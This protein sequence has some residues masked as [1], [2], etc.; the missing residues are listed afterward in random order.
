MYL[1]AAHA[2]RTKHER[3]MI[4]WAL[5]IAGKN[6]KGNSP[7][8]LLGRGYE[9][10]YLSAPIQALSDDPFTPL[11]NETEIVSTYD[12]AHCSIRVL[13]G[14]I[15][16]TPTQNALFTRIGTEASHCARCTV[17]LSTNANNTILV[18]TPNGTISAHDIDR[19]KTLAVSIVRN[20]LNELN[21]AP[22][23]IQASMF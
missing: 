17:N 10:I 18:I 2:S 6:V 16:A 19:L 14:R 12:G 13:I 1:L 23:V 21:N 15:L 3:R 7:R 8:T 22:V 20:F 11:D 4:L 5:A 9:T